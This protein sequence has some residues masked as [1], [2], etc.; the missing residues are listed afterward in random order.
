MS[1]YQGVEGAPEDIN[2][3]GFFYHIVPELA[4]AKSMDED[5]LTSRISRH[6]MP[7]PL[8]ERKISFKRSMSSSKSLAGSPVKISVSSTTFEGIDEVAIEKKEGDDLH[9]VS[10]HIREVVHRVNSGL[11]MDAVMKNQAATKIQSKFR[12]RIARRKAH[13]L[14]LVRTHLPIILLRHVSFCSLQI[15][16]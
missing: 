3:A 8:V 4:F 10:R 14:K 2:Y 6:H 16:Y 5:V 7:S 15:D 12:C 11:D 13:H 9:L 1:Y